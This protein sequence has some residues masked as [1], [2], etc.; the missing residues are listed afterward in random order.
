MKFILPISLQA[1]TDDLRLHSSPITKT[2]YVEFTKSL[3]RN[4]KGKIPL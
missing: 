1:D 3:T 2:K 4:P